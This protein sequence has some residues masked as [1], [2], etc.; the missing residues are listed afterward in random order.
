M[1]AVLYFLAITKQ[2]Q[3]ER[4]GTLWLWWNQGRRDAVT[5]C[6]EPGPGER[7]LH[8]ELVQ[9]W[10]NWFSIEEGPRAQTA[11]QPLAIPQPSVLGLGVRFGQASSRRWV[12][13]CV[14]G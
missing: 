13:D 1:S 7:L 6:E 2:T 3:I 10:G 14:V 9:H 4:L 11:A 5:H 8:H 12:E